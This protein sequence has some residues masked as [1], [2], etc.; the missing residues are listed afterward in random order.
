MSAGET[1]GTHR[2]QISGLLGVVGASVM[3]LSFQEDRV[4]AALSVDRF[5]AM[6]S[7]RLDWREAEVIERS[8]AFDA[9][10]L[11][12]LVAAY[13]GA[14]ELAVVF[15]GNFAVPSVALQAALVA[16]HA[17]TVLECSPECWIYL[18]DS[19]VLIEFHDGEGLTV[20]RIPY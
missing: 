6:G 13:A 7:S 17:E 5:G 2:E 15:W 11:C 19:G 14:D 18:T 8:E 20:G 16:S 3:V 4:F 9:G 1:Y 10:H 12:R